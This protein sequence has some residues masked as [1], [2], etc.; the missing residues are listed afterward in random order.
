MTPAIRNALIV[1]DTLA[2]V[3]VVSFAA[4]IKVWAP[5]FAEVMQ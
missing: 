4:A 3:A 2:L 5:Y 1:L